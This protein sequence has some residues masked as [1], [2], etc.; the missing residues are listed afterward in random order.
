MVLNG[1]YISC[2]LSSFYLQKE[3][4]DVP[5][6]GPVTRISSGVMHLQICAKPGAKFNNITDVNADGIGVQ[7]AAPPVDGEAN[8]ELVKYMSKV[9]GVKKSEVSLE[10]GSKSRNKC[11]AVSSS[12]LDEGAILQKIHKEIGDG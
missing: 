10:K 6:A 11:I 9:L 8:A 12:E 3:K 2:S 1:V 5:A 4:V 7:I